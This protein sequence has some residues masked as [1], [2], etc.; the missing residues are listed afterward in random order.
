LKDGEIAL[1]LMKF[2]VFEK[3][4]L[5]ECFLHAFIKIRVRGKHLRAV[6]SAIK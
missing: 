2:V 6:Q 4:V 1:V 5:I 3:I